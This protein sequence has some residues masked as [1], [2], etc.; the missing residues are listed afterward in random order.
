MQ[1]PFGNLYLVS[2]RVTGWEEM[3]SQAAHDEESAGHDVREN[4]SHNDV[5]EAQTS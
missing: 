2:C 5:K 3:P 4:V 1:I